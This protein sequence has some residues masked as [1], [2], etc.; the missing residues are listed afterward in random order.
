MKRVMI[1]FMFSIW[2]ICISYAVTSAFEKE[3]AIQEIIHLYSP[4]LIKFCDHRKIIVAENGG[5]GA[6][7]K[8]V[9][10]Y[11]KRY[12]SS[13]VL[14]FVAVDAIDASTNDIEYYYCDAEDYFDEIP[15]YVKFPQW[16]EV[17]PY[18]VSE[19]EHE[20]AWFGLTGGHYL[21]T[22]SWYY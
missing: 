22:L 21:E 20:K 5:Q 12:G 17:M 16:K 13:S 8:L 4:E 15:S 3:K 18:K 2:A 11:G 19:E 9:F 10:R 14:N 1:I 6:F 7:V